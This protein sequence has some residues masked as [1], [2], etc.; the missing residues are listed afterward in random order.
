MLFL[1]K[2]LNNLQKFMI[3]QFQFLIFFRETRKLIFEI[4]ISCD[5]L[6]FVFFEE[7]VLFLKFGNFLAKINVLIFHKRELILYVLIVLVCDNNFFLFMW[8]VFLSYSALNIQ[9]TSS[10][11]RIIQQWKFP[12]TLSAVFRLERIF[13]TDE[14]LEVIFL[15]KLR[16]DQ[17][18]ISLWF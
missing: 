15:K 13:A 11:M 18:Q 7:L 12:W 14:I 3:V 6:G 2:F 8:F 5:Q 4:F 10:S 16:F 17:I 9:K 1:L